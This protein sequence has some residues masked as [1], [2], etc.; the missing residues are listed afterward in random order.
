MV[1]PKALVSEGSA[2]FTTGL[3]L[4]SIAFAQL[5]NNLPLLIRIID[6]KL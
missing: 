6:L 1:G 3:I 2:A 4:V 5:R